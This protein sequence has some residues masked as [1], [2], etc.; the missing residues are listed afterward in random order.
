MNKYLLSALSFI[1]LTQAASAAEVKYTLT[2]NGVQP[3]ELPVLELK[4]PGPPP[5]LPVPISLE[6][7]GHEHTFYI[8][9]EDYRGQVFFSSDIHDLPC[10]EKKYPDVIE[11]LPFANGG[12]LHLELEVF[13]GG[14][15][16]CLGDY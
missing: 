16:S 2:L 8:P 6:N 13:R 12:T 15:I 4:L 3:H 5:M 9:D 7:T 10:K 14:K 1:A 11:S